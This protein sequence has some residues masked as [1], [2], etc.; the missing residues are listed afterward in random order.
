MSVAGGAHLLRE[1]RPELGARRADQGAAGRRRPRRRRALS[2]PSC[3]PSSG[4]RT[5]TSRRSQDIHS[6]KRQINA[7]RGGGRIAVAGHDIKIGRGGIREIEFFAQTQQLIWGGRLPELRVGR[8]ARRCGARRRRPH[9]RRSRRR[10]LI[11]ALPLPAPGRAPAADGRRRAD[12]RAAGRRDGLARARD[13]SRLS[14]TP[15]AFAADL[16][17]A[18]APRSS[19]IMPS[20]SRRRRRLAGPGNLVFT[21]TEDDPETLATLARLG[22]ADPPA[23]AAMVRGWHHGRYRATRSQ[24]AREILTELVPELLRVFG[25]HGQSRRGLRALRPVPGA[26]AGRGAALLAVP[27]QPGAA[28]RSSPRSWP[29]APRLAEE[30]AQRPALLDAVLTARL[31]RAAAGARRA[32]PPSSTRMLAGARDFEDML[33]LARRWAGERKFQVGVQLLRRPARRRARRRRPSPIS[34]RPAIA[35]AAAA[36]STAEFARRHGAVAGRRVRGRSAWAG[37]AAAR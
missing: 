26:P 1:R 37:S 21:G 15:T 34:P 3:S 18:S 25:A 17:R 16:L 33:D 9:R 32:W 12:P 28:R 11:D 24:R 35:G 36:R 13:L 27:R 4:A 2:S 22:F 20:S 31:L 23:V 6:I 8:P 10:T 19:G 14:P 29:A 7:H 30:L 5:S